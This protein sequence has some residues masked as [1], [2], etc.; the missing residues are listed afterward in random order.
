MIRVSSFTFPSHVCAVIHRDGCPDEF[1]VDDAGKPCRF[2]T[3]AEAIRAGRASIQSERDTRSSSII[4]PLGITE[5]RRQKEQDLAEER[6]RVFGSDEPQFLIRRGRAV[7][8][9][10]RKR[11]R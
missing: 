4:D 11:R 8:V 7:V 2:E 5:W 9:E 10:T 6:A 1:L 3:A